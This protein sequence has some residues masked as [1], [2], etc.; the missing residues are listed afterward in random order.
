MGRPHK[1]KKARVLKAHNL[2]AQSGIALDKVAKRYRVA[3]ITRP[4]G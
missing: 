4:T 2:I 3:P 1:L